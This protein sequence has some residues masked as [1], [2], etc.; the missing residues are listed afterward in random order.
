VS[1]PIYTAQLTLDPNRDVTVIAAGLLGSPAP[2][3]AFRLIVT[4][5]DWGAPGGLT[6]RTRIVHASPDA[7]TVGIDVGAD[8]SD[9]IT[10]LTRFTD[11]GAAGVEL[12]AGHGLQVATTAGGSGISFSLPAFAAGDE[13]MVIATGL[14]SSRANAVDAFGLLALDADGVIGF[15]RQNPVIYALHASPDAPAV[16][17]QAGGG[18]LINDLG[19]RDLSAPV[20]VPPGSY[21]LDIVEGSRQGYVASVF[22]PTLNPGESYLVVA[23]GFLQ[24]PAGLQTVLISDSA[25]LGDDPT[26]QIV[27]ASPDAPAVEVGVA[28]PT[29][30]VPLTAPFVFT[31]QVDPAGLA[32]P[33]G[34]Y[35]LAVALPGGPVLSTFDGIPLAPGD[36]YLAVATGSVAQGTFGLTLV[37]PTSRP[38]QTVTIDPR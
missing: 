21:I 18:T 32:V 6:F 27:H 14:L 22:T 29:G 13:V 35:D 7:P 34:V 19:F 15:V 10:G 25:T 37:D 3:E 4:Q 16:D 9:E 28:S 12:T 5:D 33:P 36:R 20:R 1:A 8:G 24:S 31:Q 11:T 2:S 26:L 30:F 38:W 17:V 23:S